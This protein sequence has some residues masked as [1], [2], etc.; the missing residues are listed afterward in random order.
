MKNTAKMSLAERQEISNSL[1]RNIAKMT[2]PDRQEIASTALYI[3]T[4][5]ACS[6]I[7]ER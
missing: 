3:C 5:S 4:G 1:M 7:A 6:Y 2:L